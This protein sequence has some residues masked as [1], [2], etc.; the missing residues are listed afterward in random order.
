MNEHVTNLFL[1]NKRVETSR[2]VTF[3]GSFF[4]SIPACC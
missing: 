4:T 1:V 2:T 3:N